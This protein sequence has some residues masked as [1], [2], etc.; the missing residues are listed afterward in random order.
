MRWSFFFRILFVIYC[1]EAGVFLVMAPWSPGWDHALLSLHLPG[2][3]GFWL[4]PGLRGIA[5]GFGLL[6]L[7]WGAHDLDQYLLHRRSRG[8]ATPSSLENPPSP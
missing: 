7:V 8:E 5:S 4:H 1:I 6:H 3:Y 2:S